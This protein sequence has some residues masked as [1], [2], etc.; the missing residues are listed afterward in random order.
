MGLR[1][2]SA[3]RTRAAD[4]SGSPCTHSVLLED[5]LAQQLG[6]EVLVEVTPQ[7]MGV[8]SIVAV[9][10][11]EVRLVRQKLD[12]REPERALA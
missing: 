5:V 6:A 11:A 8:V 9:Q 3:G 1:T 2:L 10:E 4:S 12:L 7:S